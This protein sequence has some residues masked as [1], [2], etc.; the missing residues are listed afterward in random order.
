MIR[1]EQGDARVLRRLGGVRPGVRPPTG[2]RAL[3]DVLRLARAILLLRWP[4]AAVGAA[5]TPVT[6]ER[7]AR[8]G[9]LL[10]VARRIPQSVRQSV[11]DP[12]R[13]RI[14]QSVRESVRDPY[15]L[16]IHF[17]PASQLRDPMGRRSPMEAAI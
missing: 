5:H 2:G 16:R 1:I 4:S 3:G 15:R 17:L 6:P 8:V 7:R 11:R 12:Y 14:P 9:S 10:P 13:V